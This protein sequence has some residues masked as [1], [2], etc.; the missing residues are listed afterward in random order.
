VLAV[1]RHDPVSALSVVQSSLDDA[2]LPR[3]ITRSL[4]AKLSAAQQSFARENMT[5]GLK[6]LEAFR[7]EVLAQKGK[8]I[9]AETADSLLAHVDL[10]LGCLA[11]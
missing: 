2:D 11:G 9:P 8:K 3:G 10:I 1:T 6:Q 7:R 4:S 5:A